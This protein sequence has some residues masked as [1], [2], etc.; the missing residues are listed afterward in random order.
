MWA[1]RRRLIIIF[2]VLVF[3]ALVVGAVFAVQII[4]EQPL[5]TDNKRNGSE[6]GIDC[7][8]ACARVCYSETHPLFVNWARVVPVTDKVF[9]VAL[10]VENRNYDA[11]AH[12]VEYRCD[13]MT[14]DF[15]T[16]QQVADTV[17]VPSS[18][19]YR[20]AITGL[21]FASV[22]VRPTRAKC[23]FD[24]QHQW[25]RLPAK[26]T[27]SP[28]DIHSETLIA[29]DRP[30]AS[31]VIVNTD[32]MRTFKNMSVV[33]VVFDK[34]DTVVAVSTTAIDRLEPIKS[35]E[36]VF[37]WPNPFIGVEPYR[38]EFSPVFDFPDYASSVR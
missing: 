24:S 17:S 15:R 5:C 29:D 11:L 38:A 28:F 12:R 32:N 20:F 14:E 19:R 27:P 1:F 23:V 8:G 13:L 22:D 16:V 7:G 35:K 10:E 25:L 26:T 36:L 3:C 33:V 30:S 21:R 9:S 6:T 37:T 4:T 34:L 2:V 18:G 31:A